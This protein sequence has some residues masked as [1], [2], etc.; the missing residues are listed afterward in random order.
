MSISSFK[1]PGETVTV[2]SWADFAP[3]SPH[4]IVTHDPS[5]GVWTAAIDVPSRGWAILVVDA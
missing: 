1:G 2:T 5:N 4:A 3:T